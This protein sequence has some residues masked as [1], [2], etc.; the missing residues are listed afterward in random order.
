M[1]KDFQLDSNLVKRVASPLFQYPFHLELAEQYIQCVLEHYH[2]RKYYLHS[3]SKQA[4]L[5]DIILQSRM[6]LYHWLQI[7][8]HRKAGSIQ[9]V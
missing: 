1:P 6:N 4:K 9:I 2:V 5:G 3:R 8:D 7:V